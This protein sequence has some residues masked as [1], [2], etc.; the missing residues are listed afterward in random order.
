MIDDAF[1]MWKSDIHFKLA[2]IVTMIVVCRPDFA[3]GQDSQ[4]LEAKK[5]ARK[6][7]QSLEITT[8]RANSWIFMPGLHPRLV[9]R[10]ATEAKRLGAHADFVVRWF[11]SDLHE[12]PQPDAPGRWSAWLEG[13]APNGTP[14]RRSF[15]FFAMPNLNGAGYLPD[16]TA[17]FPNFPNPD[18]PAAWKE[19]QAEFDR[20]A[21]DLLFRSLADSEQ[22]AILFAGIAESKELGRPKR[23]SEW[24]A[25]VNC[26]AQLK[27]K[28]KMLGLEDRVQA[29]KPPRKREVPAASLREGKAAEARVSETAKESIEKF[30]QEWVTATGEPFVILV[31]KNGV[32]VTH[33]AFG[34]E[35][36][37]KSIDLNYRCWTA[38]ITKLVTALMFSQFADQGLIPFDAKLNQVFPDYP[39][40]PCV[41]T[42]AQLLSHTSGLSGHAEWGGMRNPHLENIIL[43]G[44]D[45]NQPESKYEY[46]GLGFELAAKAMEMVTGTN[47]AQLY[48]DHFFVPLGFG[49][50]ILGNASSDGEFTAMELAILGQWMLNQG[51]YGNLEFIS[52][53]TFRK[54][55]PKKLDIPGATVEQGL[56]FHRVNHLRAAVNPDSP[57]PGDQLFSEHTFGHGSFSGCIFLVDP[58][59]NLIITQV[60]RKQNP[61]DQS[62]YAKFFQVIADSLHVESNQPASGR[63]RN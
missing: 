31:A 39:N 55:L 28:L 14:F 9:W 52:P 13:L 27:L 35:L 22:G 47:A 38:S 10:D 7:F 45:V 33:R 29:L 43:N 36:D 23:F 15:T 4:S 5:A 12:A 19:H 51:S 58:Q 21:K 42:F 63:E 62:Y 20:I 1:G 24:T 11:N 25:A 3:C 30:C 57:E 18:T 60:R 37:G 44:I 2:V 54:M 56:G 34:T 16:L 26:Q 41:P 48:Q 32:I 59:Q 61:P 8:S 49:D 53:A 17:K 46:C 6:E 50:V 40:S